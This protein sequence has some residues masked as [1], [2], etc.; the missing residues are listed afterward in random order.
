MTKTEV[1]PSDEF[2]RSKCTSFQDKRCM[3]QTF[4]FQL[5]VIFITKKFLCF[6]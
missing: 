4:L 6:L 2:V 5:R 3:A 1:F